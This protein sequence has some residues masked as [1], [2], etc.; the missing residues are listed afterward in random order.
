MGGQ[1]GGHWGLVA[2]PWWSSRDPGWVWGPHP[3]PSLGPSAVGLCSP[4]SCR[5]HQG[6]IHGGSTVGQGPPLPGAGPT[7]PGA[8]AGFMSPP[9]M[10]QGEG[11]CRSPLVAGLACVCLVPPPRWDPAPWWH[12]PVH[13]GAPQ[14]H[15]GCSAGTGAQAPAPLLH[16]TPCSK[17]TPGRP[18]GVC[19]GPGLTRSAAGEG[20]RRGGAGSAGRSPSPPGTAPPA[21]CRRRSRTCSAAG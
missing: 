15:S 7:M 8:V 10:A 13:P 1:W 4:L 16:R 6:S 21:P 12:S 2:W 19:P 11:V 20:L 18:Q 17:A 14:Q 9:G 5:G 3:P